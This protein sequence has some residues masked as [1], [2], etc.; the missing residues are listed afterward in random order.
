[1]SAILAFQ[2]PPGK[3]VLRGQNF[4]W[5]VILDL[6]KVGPWTVNA[7]FKRTNV[8]DRST[9]AD[10]VRRLVAGGIAEKV[11]M[12]R[13]PPSSVPRAIASCPSRCDAHA[14]DGTARRLRRTRA[15]PDVVTSCAVRLDGT[16]SPSATWFSTP[17]PM[18]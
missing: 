10:F 17:A 11:G 5:A 8:R 3:P 15:G 12:L 7:V 14:F 1:M 4:Y 13:R 9:V 18:T 2:K 16:A 6:D